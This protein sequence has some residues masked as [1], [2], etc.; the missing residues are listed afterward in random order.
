M[1]S[2]IRMRAP[3][4]Q[5]AVPLIQVDGVYIKCLAHAELRVCLPPELNLATIDPDG[6]ASPAGKALLAT[7]Q[8]E[9]KKK[10]HQVC[11]DGLARFGYSMAK[12]ATGSWCSYKPV[13][14]DDTD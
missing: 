4:W 3:T 1:I 7:P 13:L 9:F 10:V 8:D 2:Y 14:T 12:L 11:A 6:G 5:G